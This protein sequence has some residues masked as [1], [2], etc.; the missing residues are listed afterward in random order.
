MQ[1]L[2]PRQLARHR[3]LRVAEFAPN[4]SQLLLRLQHAL[5]RV[6][7]DAL[8]RLVEQAERPAVGAS[9]R[10]AVAVDGLLRRLQGGDERLGAGEG[11]E[12]GEDGGGEGLEVLVEELEGVGLRGGGTAGVAGEGGDVGGGKKGQ[13]A[14]GFGGE[15]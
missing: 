3:L 14:E 8:A 10:A 4:R 5:L 7:V 2:P 12:D 1:I 11:G 6:E 15:V 13:G 9:Q